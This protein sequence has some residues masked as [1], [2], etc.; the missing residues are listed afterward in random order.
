MVEWPKSDIHW[1]EP[2]DVTVEEF[3]DWFRSKPGRWDS[4]HPGCILYVDAAGEVG[5]IPNDTDPE[6]V[7]KLLIGGQ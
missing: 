3:L 7:R 4:S 5:E 1:A 6:T 2:R